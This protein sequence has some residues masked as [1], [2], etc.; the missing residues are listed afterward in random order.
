MRTYL[1]ERVFVLADFAPVL[2]D[3]RSLPLAFPR[4]MMVPEDRVRAWIMVSN[5]WSVSLQSHRTI[6]SQ[7][8][9]RLKG[10]ASSQGLSMRR[11][12]ILCCIQDVMMAELLQL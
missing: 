10:M 11:I 4:L 2:D 8:E 12:S 3:I 5:P 9:H 7:R 1:V 6:S